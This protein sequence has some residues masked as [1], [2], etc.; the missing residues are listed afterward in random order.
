M[1]SRQITHV[2]TFPGWIAA[3]TY[4]LGQGYRCWVVNPD[5]VVLNDGE[6]YTTSR[7]ALHA[8]R[9]FIH[10]SMGAEPDRGNRDNRLGL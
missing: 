5:F 2:L 4:D 1:A 8:G 3:I 10:Y 9:I 7:D 6:L